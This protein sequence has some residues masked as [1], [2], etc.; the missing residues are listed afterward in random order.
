MQDWDRIKITR[1]ERRESTT[2]ESG[3]VYVTVTPGEIVKLGD[4]EFFHPFSGGRPVAVT[5]VNRRDF[6]IG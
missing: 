4:E 3:E 6:Q 2:F 5:D 1:A